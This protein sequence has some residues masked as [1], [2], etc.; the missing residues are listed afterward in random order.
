M[1]KAHIN[2]FYGAIGVLERMNDTLRVFEAEFPEY[3]GGLNQF[4]RSK[5]GNWNRKNTL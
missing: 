3:F 2:R 4:A 5:H 1:A